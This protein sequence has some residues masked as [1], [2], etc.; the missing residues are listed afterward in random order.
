MDSLDI[1]PIDVFLKLSDVKYLKIYRKEDSSLKETVKHYLDKNSSHFFCRK[2]EYQLLVSY[3]LKKNIQLGNNQ[4]IH[5]IHDMA[6][7]FGVSKFVSDQIHNVAT[8]I[9]QI[10]DK[11]VNFKVHLQSMLSRGDYL[12]QHSLL[13]SF[14]AC[15]LAKEMGW[16]T[17][18][19]LDKLSYAGLLHD[20]ML[21]SDILLKIKQAKGD[22]THL[23]WQEQECYV[24]HIPQVL[25]LLSKS[26]DIPPDV[27]DI[28]SDHHELSDEK[29]FPSKKSPKFIPQINALFA[30]ADIFCHE[31]HCEKGIDIKGF[32]ENWESFYERYNK[33]NFKKP[34]ESLRRILFL[35]KEIKP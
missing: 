14:M 32:L 22:I 2:N 20:M 12:T 27:A 7:I 8:D 17:R 13:I 5:F 23:T 30:L 28:I 18:V 6:A 19:V 34:L 24:N 31:I 35:K 10:L 1:A 21:S 33:G 3:L 9:I 15:L 11:N 4:K 25:E 16:N 29:H 26:K